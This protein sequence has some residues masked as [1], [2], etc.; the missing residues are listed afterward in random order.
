M[1]KLLALLVLALVLTGCNAPKEISEDVYE[2]AEMV[3][4]TVDQK[5]AILSE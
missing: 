3:T 1:K 5:E 4:L 2:E